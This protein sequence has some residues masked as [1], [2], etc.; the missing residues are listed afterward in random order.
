MKT[1]SPSRKLS[2]TLFTSVLAIVALGG[3][4]AGAPAPADVPA[5]A[6][7]SST[8]SQNPSFSGSA[9]S[10]TA[11]AIVGNDQAGG[12]LDPA[13]ENLSWDN[14]NR[15]LGDENGGHTP[16]IG[17]S[18][19]DPTAGW[20]GDYSRM[21]TDG[22]MTFTSENTQCKVRTIQVRNQPSELVPGDDRASTLKVLAILIPGQT[23]LAAKVKDTTL[24][25]G[26]AGNPEV[27]MLS[28]TYTSG[29]SYGYTAARTF[30]KPAVTLKVEALCPSLETLKV[31]LP[32]I[33]KNV[34]IN[35]L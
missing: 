15:I 35:A 18:L 23:D 32:E 8:L 33:R 3:C 27:D 1:L 17:S 6:E 22:I 10:P 25:Y 11:E 13:T 9:A 28:L 5:T 31:T 4:A 14:G 24:G 2:F 7:A 21:A 19:T 30:S 34:T 26:M 20:K 12:R 29:D 16:D